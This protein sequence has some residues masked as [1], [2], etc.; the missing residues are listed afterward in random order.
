MLDGADCLVGGIGS[1][2]ERDGM[3]A[4][5]VSPSDTDEIIFVSAAGCCSVQFM[6]LQR[7]CESSPS[8]MVQTLRVSG[9][10]SFVFIVYVRDGGSEGSGC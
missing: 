2:G 9:F 7:L 6:L 10:P 3:A 4:W 5:G 8:G 1:P